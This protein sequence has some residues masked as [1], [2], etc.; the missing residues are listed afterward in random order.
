MK[1]LAS[2]HYIYPAVIFV[3]FLSSATVAV[4][5][6][7]ST[8]A[9]L[10]EKSKPSRRRLISVLLLLFVCTY[11]A[12]TISLVTLSIVRHEIAGTDD[13]VI[14]I[15]ACVLVFGIQYAS[16]LDS[17]HPVWHPYYGSWLLALV[18]E[19]LIAV[20]SFMTGQFKG[21]SYFDVASI[22]II[23]LRILLLV[24]TLGTY[25]ARYAASFHSASSD[26]ERQ[27]LLPTATAGRLGSSGGQPGASYGSTSQAQQ[28]QNESPEYIWEERERKAREKME[29]RL[30]EEGNWLT[31]AKRFLVGFPPCL[32]QMTSLTYSRSS[33]PISGPQAIDLSSCALSPSVPACSLGMPLTYLF[34][35]KS[36]S[37]WTRSMGEA[38]AMP[39]SKF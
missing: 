6:L 21:I 12:Q 16:L 11:I 39:G 35:D 26:K 20:L 10:D 33:G 14:N 17:E 24:T 23:A 30:Q 2:L 5:T 37:S 13:A 7:Q 27:P 34:L 9:A 32:S 15:L 3:Y 8:K 36:P 22:C 18:F 4:C 19:P 28:N 38:P 29:K 25:F 31:Y 1:L